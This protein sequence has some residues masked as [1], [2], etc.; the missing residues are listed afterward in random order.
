V[1]LASPTSDVA[2]RITVRSV[3]AATAAHYGIESGEL[4][5]E[6]RHRPLVRRRQ[7]GMYISTRL[8]MASMPMIG[9]AFGGRDHTTVLHA[10]QVVEALIGRGGEIAD[11]V[12]TIAS[13]VV[14]TATIGR[15]R[16]GLAVDTDPLRLAMEIVA[17]GADAMVVSAIDLMAIARCLLGYGI[18]LGAVSVDGATVPGPEI[19]PISVPDASLAAAV[20]DLLTARD[21]LRAAVYTAHERSA[22]DAF[23]AAILRLEDTRNRLSKGL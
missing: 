8:T 2:A 23:E 14:A 10:Q 7:V 11:D 21:R 16:P 4:L 18:R 3:I 15:L 22:R 13:A 12:E 1:T 17:G 6:R 20:G 9:R 19:C 5:S